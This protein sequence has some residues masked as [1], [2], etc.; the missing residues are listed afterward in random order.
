MGNRSATRERVRSREPTRAAWD[1]CQEQ[2][3][4]HCPGP[5][6]CSSEGEQVTLL[7]RIMPP[8]LGFPAPIE[9]CC[10]IR[11]QGSPGPLGSM[12]L[13]NMLL[14][15]RQVDLSVYLCGSCFHVN[16]GGLIFAYVTWEIGFEACGWCKQSLVGTRQD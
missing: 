12:A 8:W 16:L 1:M 9:G 5:W 7:K 10:L 6:Q 3:R 2:R 13:R 11:L 4:E 15:G 14:C